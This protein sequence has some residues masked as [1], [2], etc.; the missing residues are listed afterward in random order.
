MTINRRDIVENRSVVGRPLE[1]EPWFQGSPSN[2]PSF[3]H[4]PPPGRTA[5]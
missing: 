2:S 1:E 3:L 4:S 5:R